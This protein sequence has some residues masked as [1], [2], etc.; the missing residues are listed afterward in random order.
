VIILDTSVLY[1]LLDGRDRRHT[2]AAAWYER[3]D[4]ELATTPL[5]LAETD[6]LVRARLGPVATRSFLA[7][8]RA[9]AIEVRWWPTAAGDAAT[10]ADRYADHGVSLTDASLVA[11]AHQLRTLDIA[12]FDERHFRVLRP[13]DGG[14]AFR[15]VPTDG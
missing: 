2:V 9:G 10:V 8:V 12:T 7:D 5:V 14:A 3:L 1:A 4:A 15:L 11:L 13:L 6:H